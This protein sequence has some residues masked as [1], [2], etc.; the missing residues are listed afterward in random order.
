MYFP[1]ITSL[2]EMYIVGIFQ[3]KNE[4]TGVFFFLAVRRVF[5]DL[6]LIGPTLCPTV[7]L[8]ACFVMALKMDCP[9]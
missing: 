9:H 4:S 7:S 8:E 5:I 3:E 2:R 1:P 6:I